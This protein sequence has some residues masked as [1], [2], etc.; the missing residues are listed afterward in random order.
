MTPALRPMLAT[1]V[2]TASALPLGWHYEVKW[3]GYRAI[4]CVDKGSLRLESR[5]G[6]D[7]A[8]N[9]PE[10]GEVAQLL[11][12]HEAVLDGEVVVLDEQGRSSFEGLQTRG[13]TKVPVHLMLFDLLW[14]RGTSLLDLPYLERREFLTGLVG[15]GSAHVHV[16]TT[17][18]DERDFALEASRQLGLEG[19][20][21]KRPDGAYRPGARSADWLKFKHAN[22]QSVVV[23]GWSPGENRRAG[24]VGS[25]VMAVQSKQGLTCVGRVGTGFT[26]AMLA[27]AK[28]M[29]APLE[30]KGPTVPDATPAEA[31][32]VHWVRPELVGEVNF[33]SRT[34]S[35]RLRHPSWRG[36]RP[37]VDP[38][39]VWPE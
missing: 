18:G 37:D 38:A 5:G 35:G 24:M 1:P 4:A 31:K 11:G 39:D 21:A 17:F 13:R 30:I 2:A 36:W 22:A 3:D 16:P 28:D 23:V 12:G 9:Y 32:G 29:L 15:D 26:Q 7:L 33:L 20:L 25:L 6:I 8:P 19:V 27:E 34:N 14:L 10:L